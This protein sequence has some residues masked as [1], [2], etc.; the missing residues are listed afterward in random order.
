MQ[1]FQLKKKPFVKKMREK[2]KKWGVSS[3]APTENIFEAAGMNDE[4]MLYLC[5]HQLQNYF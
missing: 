2:G 5:E 4:Y 3:K 1:H